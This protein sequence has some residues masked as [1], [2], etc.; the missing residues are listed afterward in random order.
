LAILKLNS[1]T[2]TLALTVDERC[3]LPFCTE[4][5]IYNEN[6]QNMQNKTVKPIIVASP[7]RLWFVSGSGGRIEARCFQIIPYAGRRIKKVG[8]H[9]HIGNVPSLQSNSEN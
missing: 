1:A 3:L 8:Q 6:I 4:T 7:P 5:I 2:L 9:C